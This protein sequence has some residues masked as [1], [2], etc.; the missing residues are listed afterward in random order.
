MVIVITLAGDIR[1]YA[2]VMIRALLLF[3]FLSAG[4]TAEEIK[5]I[6]IIDSP[7]MEYF[8][9]LRVKT[10][11]D[12]PPKTDV[13]DSIYWQD[14]RREAYELCSYLKPRYNNNGGRIYR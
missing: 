5:T 9:C 4:S 6:R 11:M 14:A 2:L 10:G 1:P 13:T 3:T 7:E 12:K 8:E